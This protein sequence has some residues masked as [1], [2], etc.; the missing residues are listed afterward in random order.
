MLNAVASVP[1]YLLKSAKDY[2]ELHWWSIQ[3]K[4]TSEA[5]LIKKQST[6][7]AVSSQD[8]PWRWHLEIS[9]RSNWAADWQKG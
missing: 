2:P 6:A 1:A 9:L 7:A 4:H 5:V 8:E 3:I